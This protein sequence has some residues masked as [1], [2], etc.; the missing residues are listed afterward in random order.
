ML[1]IFFPAEAH[2]ETVV[3]KTLSE[4][5]NDAMVRTA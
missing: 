1:V 2:P 3:K 5:I 4:R